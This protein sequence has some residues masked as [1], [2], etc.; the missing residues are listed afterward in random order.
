[1]IV[2]APEIEASQDVVATVARLPDVHHFM[3]EH[4]GVRGQCLAVVP[5]PYVR[6]HV[7]DIAGR[8]GI[9]FASRLAIVPADDLL[10]VIDRIVENR[11][12][13]SSLPGCQVTRNWA[14]G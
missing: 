4:S 13:P 8:E 3:Y 9:V 12:E 11:K 6:R 14:C 1:M 10:I 2:L 7:R 5:A